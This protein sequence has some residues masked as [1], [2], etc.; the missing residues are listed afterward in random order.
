MSR[1]SEGSEAPEYTASTVS[2]L[3]PKVS[4]VRRPESGAVHENQMVARP[5]PVS[6]GGSPL[7]MVAPTLVSL[8]V[9]LVPVS[10]MEATKKSLL[11]PADTVTELLASEAADTPAELAAV[12][13]N[14]NVPGARDEMSHSSGPD[15][16]TQVNESSSTAEA[17]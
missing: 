3:E 2:K 9:P 1:V 14:V 16:H 4:T 15:V 10:S 11:V 12:T 17:M 7:S 8:A 5:E 6:I 13:V